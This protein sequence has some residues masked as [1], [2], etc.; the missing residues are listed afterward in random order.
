MP[1]LFRGR[2]LGAI[3]IADARPEDAALAYEQ[4]LL[5][6]L[7][8]ADTALAQ[9]RAYRLARR[10]AA[11]ASEAARAALQQSQRLF[12]AG[13]AGYLDVLFAEESLLEAERA[14]R[15]AERNAALAWARYMS[16][17]TAF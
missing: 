10:E 2:Q 7:S 4:T 12:S 15:A 9:T 8:D 5:S 1:L 16:A 11:S 13:E 14:E 3:D 17:L 6:A